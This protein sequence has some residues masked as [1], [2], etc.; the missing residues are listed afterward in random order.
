[1]V[2]LKSVYFERRVVATSVVAPDPRERLGGLCGAGYSA[3]PSL[4]R[5]GLTNSARTGRKM[6]MVAV[7]LANSVK[8]AM[9]EVMSITAS[10]GGRASKGCSCPPIHVDSPDSCRGRQVTAHVDA[11]LLK[12][13]DPGQG[14]GGVGRHPA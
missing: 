10:K 11:T 5:R 12:G 9:T 6:M 2:L 1:M 4:P 7:L 8:K 13:W 3:F 14:D